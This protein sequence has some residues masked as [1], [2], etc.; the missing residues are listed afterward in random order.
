MSLGRW[1]GR[2]GVAT[3]VLPGW[4]CA[5]PPAEAGPEDGSRTVQEA[6]EVPL[7]PQDA[8]EGPPDT[9]EFVT[10]A[11]SS[12]PD[13]ASNTARGPAMDVLALPAPSAQEED[14][15][16]EALRE[17]RD[18]GGAGRTQ[19][20][21]EALDSALELLPTLEDWAPLLRAQI[22]SSAGDVER[23]E[24]ALSELPPGSDLHRRW[25]HE[26]RVTAAEDADDPDRALRIA[27]EWADAEESGSRR[28]RATIRM[29][30][31]LEELGRNDEARDAYLAAL[32]EAPGSSAGLDAARAAHELGGLQAD[33]AERVGRALLDHRDWRRGRARIDPLLREGRFSGPE[34]AEIRVSLAQAHFH[35]GDFS[36]VES[37]LEPVLDGGPD[38]VEHVPPAA[39]YWQA[40]ALLELGREDRAQ[41]TLARLA[42][43][44][45]D[46]PEVRRALVLL[47]DLEEERGRRESARGYLEQLFALGVE[48]TL[49][50][51][52]AVRF[53]SVEYM[54]GSA[55][56]A[57][58]LFDLYME[59][60]RTT[61][62][63]QQAGY[64]AALAHERAGNREEAWSRLQE[65]HAHNP[66]SFYG[67]L[68]GE[69]LGEPI[70]PAGLSEGPEELEAAELDN[71]HRN[72]AARIRAHQVVPISGSLAYE[73]GRLFDH[74][75]ARGDPALYGYAE[76][77]IDAGL[78]MRGILVG[79]EIQ[80]RDG[81]W[82]LRLLSIVYPFPFRETLVE[83]AWARDLDP[84]FVAGL[85]RQ[86]SMFEP[87]IRSP[88]GAVG[89]MQIMPGTGRDLA[90]ELGIGSY[91]PAILTD[92]EVNARMGTHYL[93]SLLQR[94]DGKV[95]DALSAYNAGPS[96]ARSWQN[97]PVYRDTDV[98]IEHIPFRETRNYVKV[99]QANARIYTALYGCEDFTPCPTLTYEAYLEGKGRGLDG[100]RGASED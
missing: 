45:G 80:R 7:D 2:A 53:A 91:S 6:L 11:G 83:E 32:E 19:E 93:A 99:I 3:L 100:A 89:L 61:A 37:A 5:P 12:V 18:Q 21:L 48:E 71:E 76:H 90:R 39:L 10:Q 59:G 4:G 63:T 57:A 34:E 29:G 24:D 82:N 92:P 52:A 9:T 26:L 65:V 98:F 51:L 55:E 56:E 69:R 75:E 84:F 78:A 15:G 17:A 35:Q 13:S 44:H 60:S 46:A 96:R 1:A 85:I 88:A 54:D 66:L 68:A 16:I 72:A 42:G 86:E 22:F 20:A 47:A 74:F 94:F 33:D 73:T 27:R 81:G 31:I 40:R 49:Q 30:E 62:G 28:A 79:R 43:L 36:D 97:R 23:T 25:G 58:R 14:E 38:P 8:L 87:E 41:V 50:E 70:L 67:L 64:W 77:L 95:V